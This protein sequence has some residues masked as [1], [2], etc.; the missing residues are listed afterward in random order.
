MNYL[1]MFKKANRKEE[2]KSLELN[3][4]KTD[5]AENI[6][7]PVTLSGIVVPCSRAMDYEEAYEY[8]LACANGAEYLIEADAKWGEVL[9]TYVWQEVKV[10]GLLNLDKMTVVL[11]RVFPRGPS[12]DR[13]NIAAFAGQRGR[14]LIKKVSGDFQDL[15]FILAAVCCLDGVELSF[16]PSVAR[17]SIVA[18]SVTCLQGLT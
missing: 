10:K 9:S 7:V 16:I 18:L 12:G 4:Q 13:G 3:D 6:L 8:K 15:V 11:Q 17:T 2:N 5:Y 14:E 1:T